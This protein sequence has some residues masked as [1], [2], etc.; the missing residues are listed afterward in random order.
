MRSC[1]E[2]TACCQG[3]LSSKVV[4]IRPGVACKH[5]TSAGC[6]I[7]EDRP[8]DPCKTFKC[9]WLSDPV[10]LEE[11]LRPDRCG[12]IARFTVWKS[13]T[14]LAAVPVGTNVPQSTLDKM[15]GYAQS[16]GVP[17]VWTE[18]A[19]NFPEDQSLR[20]FAVGSEE[21][22]AQV[23]WGGFSEEDFLEL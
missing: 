21:F 5:C 20:R 19:Q 23:K 15:R 3:W 2:C 1:G 12:A 7:Y 6:A 4:G 16:K 18:R 22:L 17:L 11:E 8:E 13:Q 10:G 9:R 14:L